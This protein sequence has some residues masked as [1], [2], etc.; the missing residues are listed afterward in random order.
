MAVLFH[1][2]RTMQA[3][4]FSG[5]PQDDE[6]SGTELGAPTPAPEHGWLERSPPLGSI[7]GRP[8][9]WQAIRHRTSFGEY[10]PE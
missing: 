7:N 4:G 8:P 9:P 3:K 2:S 5:L 1:R 6:R 10:G